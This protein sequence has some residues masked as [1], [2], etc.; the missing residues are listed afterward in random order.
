MPTAV[1]APPTAAPMRYMQGIAVP[2]ESVR[3]N[4]FFARTRR[5][6]SIE[7]TTSY[8]GLGGQDFVEIRK[9]D[10]LAGVLVKFSG[11]VV[12]TT[13][14]GT[15]TT[16]GRWPYDLIRGLRFTANGQSNVI[17]CSGLKL[18]AREFMSRQDLDDRGI[19]QTMSGAAR[20]QGTL[21]QASESWG[22][23]QASAVTAGTYPIELEWWVPVADDQV[24]LAGAIFAATSSTD[25]TIT[26][27]WES[28]A[29]LFVLT[30]GA[31][32][33]VSGTVSFIST[34]YSIPLGA[35]GQIVV[36]DLSVFHSLIQTRTA[37]VN[38]DNELRLIGQ[39]AGKSLLRTFYQVWNGTAPSVTP[40]AVNATN[41]GRQAWRFAGNETP[42]EFIDGQ[43]LREM[44]ERTYN[45]DVGAVWGFMCHDF[46]AENAFRDVVDMG[47]TSELRL[48]SNIPNAVSLT[49]AAV[50]YCQETIFMAGAG[51]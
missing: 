13:P 38:G 47:T 43:H 31:T 17:N 6:T 50:E 2:A 33:V 1:A 11:S 35:D 45:T 41:F 14:S 9:A 28:Q 48:F 49:A 26:I 21:A 25:L 18:K 42:D 3:P 37:M 27:D 34:K 40:L 51:S 8:A 12:V 46:A 23:G 32:V 10:I 19:S 44:N 24:D 30:G 16:T 7:K 5:H 36:P 29:N 20:T 22:A 15:C 39:G 4:E